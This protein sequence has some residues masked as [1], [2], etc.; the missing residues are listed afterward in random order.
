M[1]NYIRGVCAIAISC[2]V[3]LNI[4][5]NLSV[6]VKVPKHA[7]LKLISE[8]IRLYSM[9]RSCLYKSFSLSVFLFNLLQ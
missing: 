3:T 2:I 6:A 9:E 1:T 4:K 8:N 7:L 5:T